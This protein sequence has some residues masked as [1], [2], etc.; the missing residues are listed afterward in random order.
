MIENEQKIKEMTSINDHDDLDILDDLEDD[1][2]SDSE[3]NDD[4]NLFDEE[5]FEDFDEDIDET[6]DDEEAVENDLSINDEIIEAEAPLT[7][8]INN[9]ANI[10][11]QDI[12]LNNIKNTE[13]SNKVIDPKDILINVRA[14]IGNVVL[15]IDKL[16][17]LKSG[18]S[19]EFGELCSPIK[20]TANGKNIAEGVLVNINNR[21]GVKIITNNN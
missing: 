19:I 16:L 15:S 3:T 9:F 10:E 5:D 12:E 1:D 18:D 13:I 14:E 2:L 4:E 21:V 6:L 8:P 11:T 20:L 17:S 7:L